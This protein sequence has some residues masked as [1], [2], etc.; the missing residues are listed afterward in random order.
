M[1]TLSDYGLQLLGKRCNCN[2]HPSLAGLP[3]DH[4]EHVGG[5]RVDGFE[6]RQWL[7]VTCPKCLYGWSLRHLDI[8]GKATFDEQLL[9]EIHRYGHVVTFTRTHT[10]KELQAQLLGRR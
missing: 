4:Y 2:G 1:P 8:P 10:A 3:I 5:W 7:S 6:Y 9:E